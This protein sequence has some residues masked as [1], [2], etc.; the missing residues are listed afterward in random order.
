MPFCVPEVLFGGLMETMA[1]VLQTQDATKP[2]FAVPIHVFGSILEPADTQKRTTN[3]LLHYFNTKLWKSRFLI[4]LQCKIT[5]FEGVEKSRFQG[6]G[7]LWRFFECVSTCT[8]FCVSSKPI[9]GVRS[10]SDYPQ[11]T[12][13][14]PGKGRQQRVQSRSHA[15]QDPRGRRILILR[16]AL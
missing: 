6:F 2:L 9:G 15:Y 10:R 13:L 16:G 14:G 8:D 7:Q 1:R 5:T 12:D 11:N 4:P 3:G